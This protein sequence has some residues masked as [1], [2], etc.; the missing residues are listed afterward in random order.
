MASARAARTS[1]KKALM[2]LPDMLDMEKT[3][4]LVR[5]GRARDVAHTAIDWHHFRQVI[6][7]P[8]ERLARA[9]EAGAELGQRKI[10]GAFA[11][12]GRGIRYRKGGLDGVTMSRDQGGK[13][14]QVSTGGVEAESVVAEALEVLKRQSS[15]AFWKEYNEDEPRD[16]QGRWTTGGGGAIGGSDFRDVMLP[17]SPLREQM[18]RNEYS[19]LRSYVGP[20]YQQMNAAFRAGDKDALREA[21]PHAKGPGGAEITYA[22]IAQHMDTLLEKSTL[23]KDT[24][25]YRGIPPGVAKNYDTLKPGDTIVDHGYMST[26]H[27][28]RVAASFSTTVFSKSLMEIRSSAG[29]KALDIGT[30]FKRSQ[31]KEVLF[32]RNSVLRYTGRTGKLYRFEVVGRGSDKMVEQAQSGRGFWGRFFG[33]AETSRFVETGE[34]LVIYRQDGTVH[35]IQDGELVEKA[36]NPDQPRDERGRFVGGGGG[37]KKPATKGPSLKTAAKA[38]ASGKAASFSVNNQKITGTQRAALHDYKDGRYKEMNGHLY[39]TSVG[40]KSTAHG[41]TLSSIKAMQDAID[42]GSNT[43][44]GGVVYRGIGSHKIGDQ[45]WSKTVGKSITW[46]GFTSTSQD[47]GFAK[48]WL[49]GHPSGALFRI[50]VPRGSKAIEYG[51]V[52]GVTGDHEKEVILQSGS[53]FY[54]QSARLTSPA[55]AKYKRWEVDLVVMK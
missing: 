22:T 23:E 19:A 51:K 42:K 46:P 41:S 37:D 38:I 25:T 54:V 7:H 32:P 47:S 8:F 36:F 6:R 55:G 20:A 13:P 27:D 17:D 43:T 50:Y 24:T 39:K 31:E 15:V 3:R 12:R 21:F 10:N 48:G 18:T 44:A 45:E 14:S 30:H 4:L 2:S 16:D 52:S 49:G 26:S 35:E 28:E 9:Y 5:H 53:K 11:A 34:G 1:L 40:E 29:T 33:K